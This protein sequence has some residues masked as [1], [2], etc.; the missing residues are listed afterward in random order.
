M[1][2]INNQKGCG[3]YAETAYKAVFRQ[4]YIQHI[5]CSVSNACKCKKIEERL[6]VTNDPRLVAVTK[7]QFFLNDEGSDLDNIQDRKA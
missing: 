1:A 4:D 2:A 3:K 7:D 6:R 5:K